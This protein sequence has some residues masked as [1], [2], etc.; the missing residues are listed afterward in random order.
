M[1]IHLDCRSQY[2]FLQAVPSPEEIVRAA[3]AEKMPAV[4]LTDTNGLYAA[5]PFYQAAREAGIKPILGTWLDT[6]AGPLLL[7]AADRDGYSHLCEL[8][9]RRQ[10][11]CQNNEHR[12]S[13]ELLHAHRAGLIA[14]YAPEKNAAS[15]DSARQL[16]EVFGDAFYFEAYHFPVSSRTN[17][18][19]AEKIGRSLGV[20]LVA[21]N[22]VHFLRPEEFLHHRVLNAVR[23][24]SL[25]TRIA[26]EEIADA[27][28]YF[29]SADEM[30]RAF[31]DHPEMLRATLEIAERANL[32]LELGKIIFPEF[33][34]PAGETPFSYLWKLCFEG[35]R[36]RYRP[37][38]PEVLARL[39]HEL[40]VIEK[41]HL[42]PYFLL[43]WDIVEE[44]RRRGIPVVG[45]GSAASSIVAYCLGISR[46]CPLRWGLYFERFLNEQ[47]GDCPDIDLDIC[48]ARRDE[49][50]N[51]V[52]DRWGTAHVAMIGSF[53]TMH[54]RLAVREVAKVFGVSPG[55]VNHFTR[56]LPHRPVREILEAIRTLPE[57]RNLPVHEE[58]WKT[59]LAVA[60]RLDDFPR[61]MGIHPCGTVIAARPLTELVPLERATKGIVVTQY[62]MNAIEALGLIKMDLLGQRGLTTMSLALANIEQS[63]GA[64]PDFDAIPEGDA[65]TTEMTAAGRTLGVFQIESPGLRTLLR[66]MRAKTLDDLCH[67]IAIIR[68]GASE[69]GAKETFLRRLRGQEEVR[70]PHPQLEPLLR[71]TLGV[72]IYQEQVMQIAQAIG[73]LSL[74]EA[75]IVRRS[76]AKYSGQ[77]ERERLH[78]KFLKAAEL[79]QL[80]GAVRD[81]TWLMVEKFA[82]FAFCKAHAATYADLAYRMA[83]LKAHYPAE[84]LAAMASANA[85][86]YHV[87]AYVE[88]AKRWGCEVRLPSVNRSAVTYTTESAADP[89][90]VRAVRV[91]L[92]QVKGLRQE[93]MEAILRAREQAGDFRSLEDFLR[94]VP[95]N[96]DET[97]ALIQCG[98]MDEFGETRPA[99]LWQFNLLAKTLLRAPESREAV[100]FPITAPQ[101]SSVPLSTADYTRAQRLA[102]EQEILEIAVSGHPLDRITR[103]GEAWSTELEMLRSRRVSLLGWLITFR[104]V[105]TKNYR[106]MMFATF[107]DQRGVYEAVLF[108]EAYERYGGLVFET[109]TMRVSGRV[110]EEGLIHCDKLERVSS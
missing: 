86:F 102:C 92:M 97:E 18:R 83:Y 9:T 106:N 6:A 30:A 65:A 16:K 46:I 1:F 100:L 88:E 21:T 94:R 24:G 99:L 23:T 31:A 51:Y 39:T 72:C 66:A 80:A 67:A 2:S 56:R 78:A 14:L 11:D 107:E 19:D 40:T 87:S 49:L 104:H 55:E 34:V 60:L 54:A 17:L 84:F 47:R 37:P 52:Y 12:V 68:P 36:V 43:V 109:R 20:P 44:A 71:D 10:L 64:R 32:T 81:E 48:G 5:L 98:A 96:R 26:P 53:I 22:R 63:T 27:E 103:N 73:S 95:A 13:L 110:E 25:L 89:R 91:G 85:G 28:A 61:H 101:K 3:T 70:Y 62:D 69:Y 79:L 33:P 57:C 105:G 74:A 76:R 38:R 35:A 4:A 75:D 77:R 8:I 7:L 15:T 41:L 45:R 108:P 50:L 82:G 42:A 90:G 93:T 29:K 58:P 59:I